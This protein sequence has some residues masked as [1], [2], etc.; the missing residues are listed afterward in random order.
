[1]TRPK[2][3][4]TRNAEYAEAAAALR[5][6]SKLE[7]TAP[8][9]RRCPPGFTVDPFDTEKLIPVRSRTIGVMLANDRQRRTPAPITL[10]EVTALTLLPE[11]IHLESVDWDEIRAVRALHAHRKPA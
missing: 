11:D 8:A 9:K 5:D 7:N 10:P 3:P 4:T 6:L 2:K 1:M